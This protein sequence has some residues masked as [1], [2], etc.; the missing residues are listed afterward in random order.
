MTKK[1]GMTKKAGM[2]KR[3]DKENTNMKQKLDPIEARFNRIEGQLK[4]IKRMYTECGDCVEIVQQIQAVR[5]ALSSISRLVLTS[6]AKKCA[7]EGDVEKLEKVVEKT[8]KTI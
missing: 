6:E 3:S 8:F 7:E 1:S 2:I 5:A 4:G